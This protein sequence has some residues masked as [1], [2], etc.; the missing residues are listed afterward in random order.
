MSYNLPSP[1]NLG[2]VNDVEFSTETVLPEF[3]EASLHNRWA[4]D[5]SS[6]KNRQ[7]ANQKVHFLRRIGLYQ[8]WR[9]FW[10]LVLCAV[11]LLQL[12]MRTPFSQFGGSLWPQSC[13]PYL[14]W[15]FPT[16]CT[17]LILHHTCC[18]FSKKGDNKQ[19]N[20]FS[21][22]INLRFIYLLRVVTF[23][24]VDKMSLSCLQQVPTQQREKKTK[25]IGWNMSIVS[26]H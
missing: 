2:L 10:H 7:N 24:N 17:I 19:E 20:G 13:Q 16:P 22:F 6:V 4:F 18:G 14:N 8:N 12:M 26:L 1:Q 21:T 3:C 5:G 11:L 15:G 9:F 23:G 25:R